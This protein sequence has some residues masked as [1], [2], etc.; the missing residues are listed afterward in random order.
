ME[1]LLLRYLLCFNIFA[2]R[3]SHITQLAAI[4]G[5]DEFSSFVFPKVNITEDASRVTGI[6]VRNGKMYHHHQEVTGTTISTAVDNLL[7]YFDTFQKKIVLVG[8]NIKSFDCHVLLNTL[9]SI[10]KVQMFSDKVD[11]FLD[12]LKLFKKTHPGLVSYKQEYLCQFLGE[13][14]Y[15]SHN[16]LAD[17]RSLQLL[18]EKLDVQFEKCDLKSVCFTFE[19]A[20]KSCEYSRQMKCNL[21][22]FQH[23]VQQNVISCMIARRMAG[24]GLCFDHLIQT[25]RKHSVEGVVSLL[26]EQCGA[27]VRVT[28]SKK[29]IDRI[30]NFLTNLSES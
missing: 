25:F 14:N 17:V 22:S 12:T 5:E 16:A 29:I 8:H 19:H 23:L 27:S 24:S 20:V 26:Q 3:H 28:K 2:G 18:V 30:I 7:S 10:D 15:E 4:S 6:S 21:P 1:N 13:M 9:M 11:G